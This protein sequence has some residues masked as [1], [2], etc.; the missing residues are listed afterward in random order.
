M[1]NGIG[2]ERCPDAGLASEKFDTLLG[3]PSGITR[4]EVKSGYIAVIRWD[5][6][7][8]YIR[9]TWERWPR[10]AARCIALG[11]DPHTGEDLLDPDEYI[12]SRYKGDG[13]PLYFNQFVRSY[14]GEYRDNPVLRPLNP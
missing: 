1:I 13:D 8:G 4:E 11:F 9:T 10:H 12:Q 6:A 3:D 7:H 14:Y 5:L 2:P